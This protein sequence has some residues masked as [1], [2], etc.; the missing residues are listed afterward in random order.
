MGKIIEKTLARLEQMCGNSSLGYSSGGG[1]ICTGNS[2]E[3]D[4]PFV[5][6][7][8]YN[9]HV[10]LAQEQEVEPVKAPN[11]TTPPDTTGL[12]PEAGVMTNPDVTTDPTLTDPMGA[13]GGGTPQ[14]P[15]MPTDPSMM[16]G[17]GMPQQPLKTPPEIGRIFELKKIYAKLMSVDSFLSTSSDPEL[18]KLRNYVTKACELFETLA[19]NLDSFKPKIDETIVLFYKFLDEI[20]SILNK[21]YAD[22]SEGD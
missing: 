10:Q 6:D 14:V 12:P 5:V 17:F 2:K 20:Y 22:H 3:N 13:A 16:G 18:L 21:Y 9:T 11:A 19:A 4:V 7:T 8:P 1:P 15:G